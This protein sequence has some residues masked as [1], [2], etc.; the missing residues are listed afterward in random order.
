[1]IDLTNFFGKQD[2]LVSH[3]L[4]NDWTWERVQEFQATQFSKN[5]K[6]VRDLGNGGF[7]VGGAESIPSIKKVLEYLQPLC[8]EYHAR[9]GLYVS[10]T[11]N[12]ETFPLHSDPGQHL[13]VWQVIGSTPWQVG[14]NYFRLEQGEMFYIRPGVEHRALPDS[15]RVSISIS[16]EEFD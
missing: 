10:L 12:S 5:P 16:L 6:Y 2:G 3:S 1:M 13:W 7:T 9:A 4:L 8:P 14:D 11:D 15:P